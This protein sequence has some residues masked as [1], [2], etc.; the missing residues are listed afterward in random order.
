MKEQVTVKIKVGAAYVAVETVERVFTRRGW[1]TSI[2]YM[3]RR[4]AV[5][6]HGGSYAICV[7]PADGDVYDA[8]LKR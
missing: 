8:L 7:T 3:N 5:S 1:Q 4:F 6:W 2:R